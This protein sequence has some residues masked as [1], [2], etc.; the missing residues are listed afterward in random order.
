MAN[1]S[2]RKYDDKGV[3]A[4]A[5]HRPPIPGQSLTSNPDEPRPFEGPPEFTNFREALNSITAELL[6]EEA[7]VPL[8]E[9]IGD[10]MPIADITLQILYSGFRD[11]KWNPDLLML[12]V[13]PLMFVI[14]AL[15][16]KT[17]IE[18]R[19]TGDEEDDE[20][21]EASI[22]EGRTKNMADL[23]KQKMSQTTSIPKGAIPAEIEQQ[24]EDQMIEDQI[25]DQMEAE[26]PIIICLADVP[27]QTEGERATGEI[28][29]RAG[30]QQGYMAALCDVSDHS[31]TESYEIPITLPHKV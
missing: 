5:N 15:A 12:L 8:I 17:G 19:M 4:F 16:E 6:K 30:Y 13:E 2:Q 22:V 31:V 20:D 27:E 7:Y 26:S 23:V 25:Q 18:Y 21:E 9:A 10:G 3:E 28:K 1:P 11:G 24:I 14:M 29:Y